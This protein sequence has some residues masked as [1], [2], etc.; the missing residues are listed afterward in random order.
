MKALYKYPHSA[1]PYDRLV[2]ENRQR[3]RH[4][5]E[6]ELLDTGIFDDVSKMR[7]IAILSKAIA[8]P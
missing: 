8:L 6:F 2:Q 4:E 7:S 5:P 1:F 3:T